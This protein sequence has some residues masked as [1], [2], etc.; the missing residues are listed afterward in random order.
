MML[1]HLDSQNLPVKVVF[2]GSRDSISLRKDFN[3]KREQKK[4]K[5]VK[6]N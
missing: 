4:S 6:I 3:Q 5:E 2:F 1:Q